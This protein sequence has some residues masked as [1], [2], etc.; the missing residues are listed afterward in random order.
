MPSAKL[1][2]R[3]RDESLMKIPV[4][5]IGAGPAGLLLSQLLHRAGVASLVIE[6]RSRAYV[7]GRIRAGVLEQGT[8]SL[9]ER[10]GV[11]GRLHREGLPHEGIAIALDGEPFR[12]DLS[13]LTGKH[14]TVYGQTEITK[15]LM[16]AVAGRETGPGAVFEA[17]NVALH[18]VNGTS[19][20]VGYSLDGVNHVVECDF[21]AGC[22][23]F[24]GVCRSA[25][26]PDVRVEYE[27]VYPFGWLGIL[28][29]VPPCHHELIY[30]NHERG[31]ALASMRSADPQPVLH[32]SGGGRGCGRVAG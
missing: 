16:D 27:R 12:I 15:D 4:C 25:I 5:I 28:A 6:R 19:P 2:R 20:S 23:G 24:H 9:L 32:P 21:I 7:E 26:P 18:G 10:A 30:S 29:D 14:V 22:D 17:D 31:F 1:N 8:V 13:A 3:D 11:A